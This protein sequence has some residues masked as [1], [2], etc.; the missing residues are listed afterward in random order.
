MSG[1]AVPSATIETML[2]R[3]PI[4]ASTITRRLAW[5]L[6]NLTPYA[7][8]TIDPSARTSP[9]GNGSLTRATSNGNTSTQPSTWRSTGFGVWCSG[10]SMAIIPVLQVGQGDIIPLRRRCCIQTLLELQLAFLLQHLERRRREEPRTAFFLGMVQHIFIDAIEQ[11]A[12]QGDV[13]FLRLAQVFG[14]I[15]V[16]HCPGA[17]GV[18]WIGCMQRDLLRTRNWRAVFGEDLEMPFDGFSRHCHGV[19]QV[20]AGRVATGNIRDFHAPGMVLSPFE[21]AMGYSMFV[22]LQGRLTQ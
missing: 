2:S 22:V 9:R 17:A 16:H 8:A 5:R 11:I 20:V 4:N 7:D 15:N 14:D 13:E 3:V 10:S 6:A 1:E 19:V 12:R 21:M 18:L